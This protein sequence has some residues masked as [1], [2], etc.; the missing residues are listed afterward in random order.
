MSSIP[1]IFHG[2]ESPIHILYMLWTQN[3]AGHTGVWAEKGFYSFK[4]LL[5]RKLK[6]REPRAVHHSLVQVVPCSCR[7][8]GWP[9]FF[10]KDRVGNIWTL[11]AEAY[12]LFLAFLLVGGALTFRGLF[13]LFNG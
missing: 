10:V 2:K 3:R 4:G 9:A 5:K 12:S 13:R 8:S 11:C 6:N 7:M 1:L